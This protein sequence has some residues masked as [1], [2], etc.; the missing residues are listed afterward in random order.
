MK[1]FGKALLASGAAADS[2]IVKAMR[3]LSPFGLDIDPPPKDAIFDRMPMDR[4]AI[5]GTIDPV[6]RKMDR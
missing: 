3:G 1:V 4:P 5:P 2:N 6:H